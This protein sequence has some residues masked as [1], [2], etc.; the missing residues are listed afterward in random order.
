MKVDNQISNVGEGK[1][2]EESKKLLH[3][4]MGCCSRT[5]S[6]I[7]DLITLNYPIT[8]CLCLCVMFTYLLRK[9]SLFNKV[10][11]DEK[12]FSSLLNAHEKLEK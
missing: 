12:H 4:S 8:L 3:E 7:Q 10:A 6:G 11:F 1:L 5:E 9:C 2:V